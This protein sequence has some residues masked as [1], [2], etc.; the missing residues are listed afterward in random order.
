MAQTQKDL[1]T[2]YSKKSGASYHA[3]S[4]EV[5]EGERV[6]T[7]TKPEAAAAVDPT[8]ENHLPNASGVRPSVAASLEN[9]IEKNMAVWLALANH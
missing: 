9:S 4:V 5:I 3:I 8:E 1:N 2:R 7:G 6:K